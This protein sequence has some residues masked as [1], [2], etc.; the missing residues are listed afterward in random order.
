MTEVLDYSGF[1]EKPG[2]NLM[3]EVRELC[4]KEQDLRAKIEDLEEQLEEL[5]EEYKLVT[6]KQLPE[7]MDGFEMT[8][9]LPDGRILTIEQKVH[10][11]ISEENKPEAHKWMTEHGSGSLIKKQL[12]IPVDKKENDLIL[13]LIK[14]LR[15][16][17]PDLP[18]KIDE[19]VH[20]STLR[21]FV[22]QRLADGVEIPAKI[23]GIFTR[24]VAKVS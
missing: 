24:K 7:L 8:L 17:R 15:E 19:S 16:V 3:A 22:K 13:E 18:V 12:V 20:H 10:A 4:D 11:S 21:S 2:H 9:R 6:E 23:F 1:Q 14:K 5:Q